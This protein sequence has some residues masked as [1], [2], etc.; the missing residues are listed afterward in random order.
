MHVY[1]SNRNFHEWWGF[2]LSNPKFKVHC[3]DQKLNHFL[4]NKHR[5]EFRNLK[6]QTNKMKTAAT[7]IECPIQQSNLHP[8]VR[9]NSKIQT[10]T[11]IQPPNKL[12]NIASK[13]KVKYAYIWRNKTYNHNGFSTIL[14]TYHSPQHRCENI[15]Q[16]WMQTLQHFSFTWRS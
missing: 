11:T 12:N 3:E 15:C 6:Q 10:E 13:L 4:S 14:I 2:L 1:L 7:I 16:A 5:N 8:S 9:I